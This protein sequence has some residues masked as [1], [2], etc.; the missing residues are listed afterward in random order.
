VVST[1][2]DAAV[3]TLKEI[4]ERFVGISNLTAK[5]NNGKGVVVKSRDGN[6]FA[7]IVRPEFK[8]ELVNLQQPELRTEEI[9]PS[10]AIENCLEGFVF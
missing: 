8:E 3:Y 2:K 9:C 7:K 10:T 1:T 6:H 5:L 4:Q